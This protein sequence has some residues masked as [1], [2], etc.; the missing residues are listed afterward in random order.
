MSHGTL[1][2][3]EQSQDQTVFG[4]GLTERRAGRTRDVAVPT[5]RLFMLTAGQ[6]DDHLVLCQRGGQ[7]RARRQAIP[8]K[9]RPT[10]PTPPDSPVRQVS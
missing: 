5:H 9:T 1:S 7:R 4:V 2:F 8:A 10:C 6:V 3:I